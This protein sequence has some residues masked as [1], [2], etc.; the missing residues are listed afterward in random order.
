MPTN[1]AVREILPPKRLIWATRYSPLEH[2]ACVA[3]RQAHQLLTA[4][5]VR[6]GRHQRAHVR[7][8]HRG[9]H[10]RRRIAAGQD[11][12]PLH[13]VAK[14]PHVAGPIVR[15]QHRDRVGADLPARQAGGDRNLL[16]EKFHQ[17]GDVLAPLRE[18]RNADRHHAQA[19]E[20]ILAEAPLLDLGLHVA[21]GRRDDAHVH[22][23]PHRSADALKL[24]VGQHAQDAVLRLAR[25]VGDLVDEQRTAVRLLERT[26]LARCRCPRCRTAPL[27]CARA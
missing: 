9:G 2:F 24:L 13:V 14:L 12:Q 11:Q 1:S 27:P 15:L 18:R 20:Q 6:H 19:V 16:E 10:R 25:H 7:R 17:L 26:D 8:Q 3:Q 4:S 21:G 23:H 5:P 22:V